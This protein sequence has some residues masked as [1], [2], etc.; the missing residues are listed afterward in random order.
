MVRDWQRLDDE[1]E[2]FEH[3][4]GFSVIRGVKQQEPTP[5]FCPVCSA[6]MVKPDDRYSYAK[7]KCCLSCEIKWADTH[8]EEW[9]DGWRPSWDEVSTEIDRR[10]LLS[11]NRRH[12]QK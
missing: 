3:P 1:R 8:R 7:S 4:L 10:K 9:A 6:A 2:L 12:K 11:R 5:V